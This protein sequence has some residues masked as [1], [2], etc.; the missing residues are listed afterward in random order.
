VTH[1]EAVDPLGGAG[2]DELDSLTQL[3]EGVF[4]GVRAGETLVE[5]ELAGGWGHRA[6]AAPS[7][8]CVRGDHWRRRHLQSSSC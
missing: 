5:A 3:E 6:S 2:Q 7:V 1:D 8:R 4:L